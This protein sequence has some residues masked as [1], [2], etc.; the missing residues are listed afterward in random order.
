MSDTYVEIKEPV[1]NGKQGQEDSEL[2]RSEVI[3]RQWKV[4]EADKDTS[5]FEDQG[6]QNIFL[7]L[8]FSETASCGLGG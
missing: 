4:D 7:G 1:Y 8:V 2:D 5:A 3:Q 6:E